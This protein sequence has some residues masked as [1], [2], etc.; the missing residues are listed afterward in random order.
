MIALILY[1]NILTI[2]K[3][4]KPKLIR[5]PAEITGK[6]EERLGE[7]TKQNEKA[8]RKGHIIATC[9][10]TSKRTERIPLIE[11]IRFPKIKESISK[12]TQREQQKREKVEKI[13]KR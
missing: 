11:R 9:L 7:T 12:I 5:I 10:A 6:I 8:W 4:D 3:L 2:E 13:R 1:D